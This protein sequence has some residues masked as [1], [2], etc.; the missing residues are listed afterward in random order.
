MAEIQVQRADESEASL[1]AEI[2]NEATQTKL[3]HGDVAWGVEGWTAEEV[4]HFMQDSTSYLF[5]DSNEL[6]GTVSLQ[7]FDTEVWG[8]QTDEALYL[9]RLAVKRNAK[10][11]GLGKKIINWATNEAAAEKKDFL[12]LDCPANNLPL[13]AYYESQD[14]VK[15]KDVVDPTHPKRIVASLY[16]RCVFR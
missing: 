6:V 15:V 2:L 16:Q 13:C 10:G 5:R 7:P 11:H 1:V 9:H 8:P 3:D 14:F 12:R 4:E